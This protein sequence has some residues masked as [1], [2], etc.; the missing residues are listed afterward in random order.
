MSEGD[1]ELL[2]RLAVKFEAN[3]L[4]DKAVECWVK[5]GDFKR[6]V[7]CCVLLKNW[8]LAMELAEKHNFIQ[9]EGLLSQYATQLMSQKKKLEAAEL[10]RRAS[11]NHEAARILS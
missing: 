10:Y 1:S 7:D 5:L 3:C 8:T 4:C 6:A 11:R 2:Q 9:I